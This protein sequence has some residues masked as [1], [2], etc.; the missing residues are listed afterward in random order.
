MFTWIH[1]GIAVFFTFIL[2]AFTCLFMAGA[3]LQNHQEEAYKCGYDRG[4]DIGYG[5]GYKD[6]KESKS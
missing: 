4:Y 2:T 1:L 3:S 5:D 6:G